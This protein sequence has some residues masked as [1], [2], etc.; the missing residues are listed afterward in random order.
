MPISKAMKAVK[1][2]VRQRPAHTAAVVVETPVSGI[3]AAAV[4]AASLMA[5]SGGRTAPAHS[6]T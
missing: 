4:M 2:P 6:D 1:R 5:S 3:V